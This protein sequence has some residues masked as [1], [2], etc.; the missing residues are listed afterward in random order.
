MHPFGTE[1][2]CMIPTQFRKKFDAKSKRTILVGYTETKKNY[3]VFDPTKRRIE[4]VRNVRFNDDFVPNEE[5]ITEEEI[6]KKSDSNQSKEDEILSNH[7]CD[8]HQQKFCF[9]SIAQPQSIEEAL[10]SDENEKW[11]Q[12]MDEEIE[13]LMKNAT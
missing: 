4:V 13:S 3:R 5:L 6:N 11:K 9:T 8:S 12:A 1:V 2:Y 7:K 10:K